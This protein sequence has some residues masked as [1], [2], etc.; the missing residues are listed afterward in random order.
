MNDVHKVLLIFK[1]ELLHFP[2]LAPGT[3]DEMKDGD[4][5][6]QIGRMMPFLQV[7]IF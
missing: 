3:S 1:L 7:S 6:V 4:A 2:Y 5:Q